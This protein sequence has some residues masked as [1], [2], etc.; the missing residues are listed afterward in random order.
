MKPGIILKKLNGHESFLGDVIKLIDVAAFNWRVGSQ[1]SEGKDRAISNGDTKTGVVI[2]RHLRVSNRY[3]SAVF[4][5]LN[6]QIYVVVEVSLSEEGR[7][8][9]LL[10]GQGRQGNKKEEWKKLKFNNVLQFGFD[11]KFF[12]WL[13]SNVGKEF[14][15]D[16]DKTYKIKLTDVSNVAQLTDKAEYDSKSTGTNVLGSLP[17]LSGLGSNQSVYEAGFGFTLPKMSLTLRLADNSTCYINKDL[18]NVTSEKGETLTVDHEL[19]NVTLTVYVILLLT[20][21]KSYNA[22]IEKKTWTHNEEAS[23]RKKWA[24]FVIGELCEENNVT[25]KDIGVLFERSGKKL[26]EESIKEA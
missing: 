10:F 4:F 23:Q 6:G 22:D 3:C 12:Y 1:K 2:E 18:S 16:S 21:K 13:L 24:L 17:A 14:Q 9:S 20:L 19:V 25:L 11:S 26:I 15:H 8:R 5:D 7:V